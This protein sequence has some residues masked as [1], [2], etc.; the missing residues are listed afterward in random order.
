MRWIFLAGIFITF[1][2]IDGC[3][4]TT[5]MRLLAERLHREGISCVL[6]R[7]P[8]GTPIGDAIRALLLSPTSQ[9]TPQTEVYLYAASR[10]E[11]VQ[12]VILP[13]LMRGDI[14]LC[15]RFY[16]ASIAYQGYGIGKL[17][18]ISPA[19]VEAVNTPALAKVKPDLTFLFDLPVEVANMRMKERPGQEDRIEQR[20]EAFFA[21]V[22]EGLQTIFAQEPNRVRKL[23][24]TK[25]IEEVADE[26]YRYAKRIIEE[27]GSTR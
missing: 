6:T 13:A 12:T 1:E 11:H 7:E 9:M 16:D 26:V 4:K 18:G 20:G 14:V 17:G 5:Q 10:A 21:R 15:D 19:F 3:G 27:A 2:G 25:E 23:D 22:Q 8:G 24:A